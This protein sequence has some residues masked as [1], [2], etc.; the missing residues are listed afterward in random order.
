MWEDF[1]S[2]VHFYGPE[3]MLLKKHLLNLPDDPRY[4]WA[5]YR[6]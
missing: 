3:G 4:R 5:F 6:D 1:C 2:N